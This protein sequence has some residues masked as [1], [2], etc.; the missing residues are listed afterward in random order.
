MQLS[1]LSY[2]LLSHR[3]NYS[4]QHLI[5]KHPH[6][7]LFPQGERSSFTLLGNMDT[8][9]LI[10]IQ[11]TWKV[12]VKVKLSLC[13]TKHHTM[14]AYWGS[15]RIGPHIL[16]LGTRWRWM[17]SFTP[18]PLYHRERAPGTHWIGGWVWPRAVLDAVVKRKIPSPRREPNPRAPIVQPVK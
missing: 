9:E 1:Q 3:S 6:F 10:N 11:N 2:Y 15:G 8:N 5:L 17:V 16:N 18:W 12:K 7:G 14:K 4:P 13:L